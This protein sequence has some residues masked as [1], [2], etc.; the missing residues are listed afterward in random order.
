MVLLRGISGARERF[1][2]ASAVDG[3]RGRQEFAGEIAG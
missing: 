2:L 3:D 1:P